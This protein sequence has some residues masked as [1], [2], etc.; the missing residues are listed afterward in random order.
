MPNG[1]SRDD[2]VDCFESFTEVTTTANAEL[3]V[4]ISCDLTN[5]G[6]DVFD[7]WEFSPVSTLPTM[8]FS[9]SQI[10]LAVLLEIPLSTT[11]DMRL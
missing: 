6:D 10:N 2:G 1:F 11:R 4:K 8:M 5:A 3:A 9:T 7:E